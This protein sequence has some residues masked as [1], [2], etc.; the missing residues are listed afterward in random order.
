MAPGLSRSREFGADEGSAM[1]TGNPL[2]LA[3]ALTKMDL[4]YTMIKTGLK[5]GTRTDLMIID[6]F[7][8]K[9]MKLK[10]RLLRSHPGTADR[11]K[12]LEMLDKKMRA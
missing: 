7:D 9:K 11:V 1:I 6:P 3:S 12:R 5:P 4:A 2:A 10:D 8:P